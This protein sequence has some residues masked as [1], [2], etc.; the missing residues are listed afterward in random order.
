MF[1]ICKAK[2]EQPTAPGQG[3]SLKTNL[4]VKYQLLKLNWSYIYHIYSPCLDV[5]TMQP[6]LLYDDSKN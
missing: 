4:F 6:Y 2:D 3:K 1:K 5:C